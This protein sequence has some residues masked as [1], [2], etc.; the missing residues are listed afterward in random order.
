MGN[1]RPAGA[2]A[3]IGADRGSGYGRAGL[4]GR[5]ARRG[6]QMTTLRETTDSIRRSVADE[7]PL[8]PRRAARRFGD[9][10][11]TRISCRLAVA[12]ILLTLGAFRRQP[13]AAMADFGSRGEHY[14]EATIASAEPSP[15]WWCRSWWCS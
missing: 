11:I 5:N 7:G 3:S 6:K 13:A 15:N 12:S 4:D 8:L 14:D 10:G 2:H 9:R 1:P